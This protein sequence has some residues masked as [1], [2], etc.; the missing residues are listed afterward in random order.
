MRAQITNTM[1]VVRLTFHQFVQPICVH[2]KYRMIASMDHSNGV[3]SLDGQSLV[4]FYR[5]YCL[6]KNTA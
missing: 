4:S 2:A 5:K 3:L 6:V 1:K